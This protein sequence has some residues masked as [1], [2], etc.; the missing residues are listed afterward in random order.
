MNFQTKT[1][2]ASDVDWKTL[3]A[4]AFPFFVN[5]VVFAAWATNI[6]HVQSTFELT[7][8]EIGSLLLVVALGA[9]VFMSIT[10]VVTQTR[11]AHLLCA[12]STFAFPC[13]LI[14]TMGTGHV[15]GLICAAICLG[16]ANGSMDV[17]MNHLGTQMEAR[18]NR[19]IM[20]RLH[21]CFSI[22][23]LVGALT[24]YV[25]IELGF[26][27]VQQAICMTMGIGLALIFL[28]PVLPRTNTTQS[29][30]AKTP[31]TPFVKNRKLVL[32]AVMSFLTMLSE[33]AI[34]DWT[35]VYLIEYK[36]IST[37]SAALAFG[38]YAALMIVGRLSG[39][40]AVTWIGQPRL[41]AISGALS[42]IGIAFV[43]H[44]TSTALHFLGFGLLGFGIA[45]LI[46]VI[47]RAASKLSGVSPSFG[48]AF[49]SVAGYSGFLV[50]PALMGWVSQWIGLD[51]ALL[52]V[53]FSGFAMFCAAPSF[54]R[55]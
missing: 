55:K 24:T 45:N 22:G 53:L 31:S 42:M 12:I 48:I 1:D 7:K 26:P 20:S 6:P 25:A 51:R 21:G 41:I 33:G 43:L 40:W 30:A 44:N 4:I 46:P 38:T 18:L 15:A 3:I 11:S 54:S 13:A 52:V 27:P 35:A 49:V 17:T 50:G 19:P 34:A 10:A 16:A 8:G 14:F 29:A 36:Q 39:D 32:L 2:K 9:V 37:A 5:G 47:F 23:A 28:Y